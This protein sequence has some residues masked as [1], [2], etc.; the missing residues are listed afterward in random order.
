M[1]QFH[2]TV[3]FWLFLVIF[4]VACRRTDREGSTDGSAALQ[5]HNIPANEERTSPREREARDAGSLISLIG[6]PEHFRGGDVAVPGYLVLDRKRFPGFDGFLF[7][8]KKDAQLGFLNGVFVTISP[9]GTASDLGEGA[10]RRVEDSAARYSE[11]YVY[12]YGR[13]E[14]PSASARPHSADLG[15]ICDIRKT[16]IRQLTPPPGTE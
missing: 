8:R 1:T 10:A 2:E 4:G 16:I 11:K 14:A 15:V 12:V 7:L 13:F 5:G 6:R 3:F 9:C